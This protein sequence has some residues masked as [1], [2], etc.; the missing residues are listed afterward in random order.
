MENDKVTLDFV[1]IVFGVYYNYY[2]CIMLERFTFNFKTKRNFEKTTNLSSYYVL[3]VLYVILVYRS[4]GFSNY[5]TN[6]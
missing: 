6:I 3:K 2:T 5:M 4:S 1:S